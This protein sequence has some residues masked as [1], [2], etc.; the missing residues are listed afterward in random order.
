MADEI[1]EFLSAK[2]SANEFRAL[3]EAID[4]IRNEDACVVLN[5]DAGTT[6]RRFTAMAKSA[7]EQK[8]LKPIL[9]LR[10][11]DTPGPIERAPLNLSTSQPLEFVG[12]KIV[13]INQCDAIFTSLSAVEKFVVPYYARMRGLAECEG[14]RLRFAQDSRAVALLHLPGSVEETA[15]LADTANMFFAGAGAQK[16]AVAARLTMVPVPQYLQ[17]K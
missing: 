15:R 12:N 13:N 7:A 10:T 3:A 2:L 9:T 6:G 14:M 16:D 5:P 4:S 8:G 1:G 11:N 17:Q